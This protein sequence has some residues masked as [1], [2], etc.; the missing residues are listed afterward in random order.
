MSAAVIDE[1]HRVII[2]EKCLTGE[3]PVH[4]ED[5]DAVLH[6]NEILSIIFIRHFGHVGS[7]A[8]RY[9]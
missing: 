2:S 7:E 5:S 3:C 1:H 8:L 6:R 4:V 9:R